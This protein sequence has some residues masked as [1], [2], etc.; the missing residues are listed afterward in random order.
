MEATMKEMKRNA[1]LESK[2]D[3]RKKDAIRMVLNFIM[4]D[5]ERIIVELN[6]AWAEKERYYDLCY[7]PFN[8]DIL[9]DDVRKEWIVDALLKGKVNPKANW[10][11][12]NDNGDLLTDWGEVL[13]LEE[14]IDWIIED[15][16][17]RGVSSDAFSD[18]TLARLL[19][20]A[21]VD[22]INNTQ[23]FD[24][25]E[26][27]AEEHVT[28]IGIICTN[29]ADPTLLYELENIQKGTEDNGKKIRL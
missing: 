3:K 10:F 6:N 22:F 20:P 16:V 29:W 12:I 4:N 15:G 26:E 7:L 1:E 19:R 18:E 2:A 27:F 14:I 24:I 25:D 13:E 23:D 11:R 5:D 8:K 9:M 28:D 21:F 17:P